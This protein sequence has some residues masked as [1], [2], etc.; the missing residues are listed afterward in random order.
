MTVL[1]LK[2]SRRANAVSNLHGHVTRR[3]WSHLWPWRVEEEIPIGHI[4]NGV[5]VRGWLAPQMYRLYARTLGK[6]WIREM[7]ESLRWE[8]VSRLSDEELWE[9]HDMLK[10]RLIA[11]V[12]RRAVA[13]TEEW[14]EPVDRVQRAHESLDPDALTIGFARRFAEYK[15]AGLIFDDL[16]RLL[17]IINNPA[18]PVQFI[19][20]G[21]AHPAN[22]AGKKM[23]QRIIE[24]ARNERFQGRLAFVGD[25]DIGV[26]RH[27]VQGVDLWLNNPL[28]PNEACGTSGQKVILNGG[29]NCSILDGWW[30]EAYDG[31]NGFAIGY[32]GNHPNPE[33]QWRRDAQNLY[34][35]LEDEVIPLYFDRDDDGLPRRWLRMVKWAIFTLGWRF[36]ADRM[37]TDYFRETYLPAAGAMPSEFRDYRALRDTR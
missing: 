26:G 18:R 2:L 4:T 24:Y 31:H 28:R 30:A 13:D 11:F 37:V 14:G 34:S 7:D 25:Y 5:H 32:G 3:M 12:R 33:E 20:A 29:L 8:H 15:R 27:L 17:K 6:N 9:T 16:E 36:C 35:V 10:Q 22:E 21:K 19:F 23:I 1:A